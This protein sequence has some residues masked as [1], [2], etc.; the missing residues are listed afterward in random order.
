MGDSITNGAG[1]GSGTVVNNPVN[2]VISSGGGGTTIGNVWVQNTLTVTT[3]FTSQGTASFVNLNAQYL[4]GD[5]SN[6]SS[7]NASN[8]TS[9]TLDPSHLQPSGVTAQVYG[10]VS[11]VPQLTIDQWGRVTA[12][13]NAQTQWTPTSLFNIATSNGVSI[14]TLNDPPIGSNL[15]VRGTANVDT[16]NV[17]NLF[18]NTVTIFGLNTLNV[19]GTSNM[20]AV[21]ASNY[22]G[23]ASRLS[24]ISGSSISGNV[25][26]STVALV[27]SGGA[28]PN[29]TS[30]GT[31]TGLNI[32]GLL[33]VSNGYGISNINGANVSGNVANSTVALVVSGGAQPNITSV[34]TLTGLK[35]QGLLVASDGS[36]I[37]GINGS[38]LVGNVASANLALIVTGS[39]QPNI[40]NVGTLSNL[41]VSGLL[42]ASNAS[43]LSN[44]NGSN[45]TG[46]VANSTVALVVSGGAQP[47]ITSVGTLTGLKI[48]GLLIASDGSGIS[49]INGSNL[50]GNVANSNVALV[51]SG[52]AQPNITSVGTLTGLNIQGLLI[53]S[54]GSGISNING[55]NVSGNVAN[56]TVALVVSGGAQ[57]NIMSVGILSNLTVSGFII[58]SNGYGIS[59]LNASN[60]T[61]NVANSNVALVVSQAAQ[62]NITS[63][64]TLTSL[65]IQGLLIVSNGSGIANISASNISGTVATAGVVTNPAQ[66]N[67]TSV[68][69]LTSLEVTGV[70][71]AG[72]FTGNGSALSNLQASNIIGSFPLADSV[73]LPAQPNITSVGLLSN[74]AVSNSVTTGN[75]WANSLSVTALSGKNPVQ[76]VSDS[77]SFLMTNTGRI[78][79]NLTN[80]TSQLEIFQSGASTVAINLSDTVVG[81]GGGVRLTK[82]SSQNMILENDS[83]GTA[84]SL[85]NNYSTTR[86]RMYATLGQ[87]LVEPIYIGPT[88]IPSPSQTTA[89]YIVGNA[90]VSNSVTTTNIYATQGYFSGV[91]ISPG[92]MSA[93]GFSGTNFTGTNFNIVSGGNISIAGSLATSGYYL[94]TT[95]TQV[96]WAP[97]ATVSTTFTGSAFNGGT[98]QGSTFSG[99]TITASTG[100]TGAAFSGGTFQGSTVSGT[101]ITASTG[102]TGA[103]YTGGTFYGGVHSGTTIT[104]STGFTGAAFTGSSFNFP[105]GGNITIAGSTATS[106][107][108]L[109]TNGTQVQWAAAVSTAFS[110]ATVFVT[111]QVSIGSSF[112]ATYPLSVNGTAGS[113]A[114]PYSNLS[115]NTGG[116]YQAY[117]PT[118]ATTLQIYTPGRIGCSE[119]DVLSDRRIKTQIQDTED[120]IDLIRKLRVRNFRYIDPV[121][122]GTKTY[123][124]LIAQEVRE[125]I[126]EAVGLHE[127]AIPDIFQVATDIQDSSCLL[128]PGEFTIKIGDVIK[129]MDGETSKNLTV[130]DLSEGRVNFDSKLESQKV[131]VYG[132][133]V[134]DFHTVSYDRLVPILIRSVQQLIDHQYRPTTP[135]SSDGYTS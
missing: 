126:P 40:T 62:P 133:V 16:M 55:A 26:N 115:Y 33:I 35:I 89:L 51:V 25:A 83:G 128:S 15:Y 46:N 29:I 107:Y 68:G 41:T 58:S 67:I 127:G 59:N 22:Y 96:Q 39:N 105:S 18:A 66:V 44:I 82:D 120:C 52:G 134:S 11:N 28:Q 111:G 65:N 110:G 54:N 74:L 6:I 53:V 43:G 37:S 84:D 103:A 119:V 64:G 130:L 87:A 80:P 12:A 49:G 56:S 32:Q 85:I 102:F 34:G 21:Y 76:F 23:N 9:G 24:N 4:I 106:G 57:P 14:G 94:Q 81:P 114:A 19:Y 108:Y 7:L 61:G 97:A 92:I 31:L 36:G 63:V 69:T 132:H 60:L 95:G 8:I 117:E 27:V 48:Q 38:N 98:F 50:V 100:F 71:K 91:T 99:T 45:V 75:V 10:G 123:K 2:V 104:A 113:V 109:Q 135:T 121:E 30:V 124:G 118:L 101:T 112:S 42:I 72:L 13:T 70:I 78:G 129:V 5:G 73:S 125:V 131:F 86:F 3:A 79:I 122:H 88:T 77:G 116:W 20:N 1:C 17:N 93:P 90:Y 47:N